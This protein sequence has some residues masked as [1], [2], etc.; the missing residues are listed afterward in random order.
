MT[1]INVSESLRRHDD[2]T[3]MT[4]CLHSGVA[5]L[6][7]DTA[8]IVPVSGHHDVSLLSP[9]GAPATNTKNNRIIITY[10][11]QTNIIYLE[12]AATCK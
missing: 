4:S 5:G 8:V 9:G 3:T 10:R 6:G 7:G 11:H 1:R 2:V 12:D